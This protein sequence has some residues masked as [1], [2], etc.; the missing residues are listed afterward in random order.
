M[1]LSPPGGE[2]GWNSVNPIVVFEVQ[3]NKSPQLS[4]AHLPPSPCTNRP[5]VLLGASQKCNRECG[6]SGK[7]NKQD[8]WSHIRCSCGFMN[9]FSYPQAPLLSIPGIQLQPTRRPAPSPP[10]CCYCCSASHVA[11]AIPEL[12]RIPTAPEFS[13]WAG[14]L[15]LQVA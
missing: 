15:S 9:L 6:I 13:T 8:T 3:E 7:G 5:S 12:P 4:L 11:M 10:P 1:A 2:A 14:Q